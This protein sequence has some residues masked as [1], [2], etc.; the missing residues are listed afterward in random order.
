MLQ[1]DARVRAREQK[2]MSATTDTDVII[3]SITMDVICEIE[4]EL[5]ETPYDM[6]SLVFL[7]YEVPDTALQRLLVYQRISND[8]YSTN[9]NLLQ[10]WMLVAKAKPTWRHELLEA[11]VI[12]QLYGVVRKLGYN[13][14]NVKRQYQPDNINYNMYVNPIK[15]TLYKLCEKIDANNLNTLKRSLQ[16]YNIDTTDYESCEL[17][18]LK[19]MSE[20]VMN[21]NK[22]QLQDKRSQSEFNFEKLMKLFR[23]LQG[24]QLFTHELCVLENC[25]S[26]EYMGQPAASSSPSFNPM[27]DVSMPVPSSSH[28]KE[29][30]Y[31]N[32]D[33]TSVFN[34]FEDLNFEESQIKADS[35]KYVADR[36]QIKD[37]NNLGLCLIIN[38][39]DF[40][41]CDQS[42]EDGNLKTSLAKRKGST[43]DKIAL[44]K[45]MSS[46]N[47]EVIGKDN[48]DHVEMVNFIK[49]S[50]KE[51]AKSTTS[52]FMLCILSH[53]VRDHVFAADCV[54][55]K[56]EDIQ[57]LLDSEDA[58]CLRGIP[59]VLILQACQI[60]DLPQLTMVADSPRSHEFYLGK[61]DFLVY[62]AT[63]PEYEA[64]RAEEAG[65]IFIQCLCQFVHKQRKKEHLQDIFTNNNNAVHYYCSKLLKHQMP[66]VKTSLR[67]KLYLCQ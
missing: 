34:L 57:K 39:E 24:L 32:H 30:R 56:V 2:P 64:F 60:D 20:K 41:L 14:E 5:L 1:S 42:I 18:F 35:K 52:V 16:T 33:F 63:S 22:F 40:H 25:G 23:K 31:E 58:L 46:L 59:K 47:F 9:M 4:K 21:F 67:K 65:S 48:L 13:I 37:L 53:G 3:N 17:V 55:V 10:E 44:Q 28:I 45:T 27:S 12:C 6:I 51:C 66:L 7:L 26:N 15:K 36:Y 8:I 38:Q 61:S 43:F 49:R 54:K 11:L 50:I 19:L 62:W 29:Q